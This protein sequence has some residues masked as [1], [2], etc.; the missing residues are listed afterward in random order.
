MKFV[1]IV[2][3]LADKKYTVII[4]THD[5]SLVENLVS[6]KTYIMDKGILDKNKI[7][8]NKITH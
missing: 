4:V 3:D 8:I 6:I 7:I 1:E 2:N 5:S